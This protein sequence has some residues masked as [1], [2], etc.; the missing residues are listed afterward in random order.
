MTFEQELLLLLQQNLSWDINL[1]KIIQDYVVDAALIKILCHLDA[2]VEPV[3]NL[4]NKLIATQWNAHLFEGTWSSTK[5]FLV[6][7]A[8]S[9]RK[10]LSCK[11]HEPR[12]ARP[13]GSKDL[14][15]AQGMVVFVLILHERLGMQSYQCT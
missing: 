3:Q 6:S 7:F 15:S 4:V 14:L 5:R 12:I 1:C 11:L 8:I 13:W 9:F 10:H 2:I